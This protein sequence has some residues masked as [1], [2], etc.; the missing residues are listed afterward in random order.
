M[1]NS[2]A[3]FFTNSL[4]FAGSSVTLPLTSA[5]ISMKFARTLASSVRGLRSVSKTTRSSTRT[6]PATTPMPIPRPH[7]LRSKLSATGSICSSSTEENQPQKAR[8]QNDRAGIKQRQR[9]YLCLQTKAQKDCPH[10]KRQNHAQR[11]ADHPCREKG[12]DD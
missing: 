4:S 7:R 5:T 11:Q 12:A 6:A 9:T 2:R 10:H 8:Q 1:T 3:P